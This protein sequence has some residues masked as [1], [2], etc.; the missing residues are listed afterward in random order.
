MR[1]APGP[2]PVGETEKVDFVDGV[3]HLD[4]CPLEDLV[5]QRGDS[6]RSQPPVGFRYVRPASRHC[7]V[8]APHH[9]VVE[10]FEVIL[11]LHPVVMPP[12]PVHS[13]RGARAD[14]P[15]GLPQAVDGEMV[16]K[17]GETHI[18]VRSRQL[19]HTIQ[20]A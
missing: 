8:G 13:R 9:P 12:H 1:R 2:E 3:Q 17:R 4:H 14:R 6:E 5:L 15:V 18:P 20:F 19:A 10:I 16:Q 7:P 11:E